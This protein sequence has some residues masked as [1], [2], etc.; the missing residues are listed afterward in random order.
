M[1]PAEQMGVLAEAAEGGSVV[2][3]MFEHGAIRI[4]SIEGHQEVARGR[5]GIGVEGGAQLPDLFRGARAEAGG[6]PL[7]AIGLL[8]GG[9]GACRK[10]T[11]IRRQAP[12]SVGSTSEVCRKRWARTKLV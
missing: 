9:V 12:S 4:A 11:G 10:A 6:A 1:G 8:L 5:S 2:G 7:G 3:E